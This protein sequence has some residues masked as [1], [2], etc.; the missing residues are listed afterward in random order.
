VHG[1]FRESEPHAAVLAVRSSIADLLSDGLMEQI[2]LDGLAA[3]LVRAL[4]E[5]VLRRV[6]D[7]DWKMHTF[8]HPRDSGGMLFHLFEER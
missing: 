6:I 8:V 7:S 1:A 4:A 3:P 5:D 2:E